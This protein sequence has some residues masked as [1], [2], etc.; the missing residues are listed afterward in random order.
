MHSRGGLRALSTPVDWLDRQPL[1]TQ[2]TILVVALLAAAASAVVVQRLTT[3]ALRLIEGY[4][5]RALRPLQRRLADRVKRHAERM[6]EQ[7]RTLAPIV[8]GH[9][10]TVEQTAEFVALDQRLRRL[11]GHGRYLPTRV[12]NT[13]RAGESRPVDK[14]GL[15]AVSLWPHLWLLMPETVRQELT[16]ARASLDT[17]VGACLWGLLFLAFTPWTL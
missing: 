13:L 4:W 8:L 15:D 16:T 10:A 6:Q 17:S 5:P 3:P 9:E 2:V 7:F 11:P 12:G 1:P 14:Y